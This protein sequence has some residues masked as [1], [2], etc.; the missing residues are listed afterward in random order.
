M[1]TIYLLRHG[2]VEKKYLDCF[3]GKIDCNLSTKG[4]KTSLK[5]AH[6]LLSQSIDFVI[7]SG[8]KRTDYVGKLLKKQGITHQV[9]SDFQE[10]DFGDC[11]G[12]TWAEI[13][14]KFP[15]VVNSYITD[16][17]SLQYPN[18]EKIL[19]AQTRV[20][21]AW[22]KLLNTTFTKA[23]IVGHSGINALLIAYLNQVDINNVET[24]SLGDIIELRV[25]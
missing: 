10:I 24:Q 8:L 6:F 19:D 11:S 7:T 13:Q 22:K 17:K 4:K 23:A 9:I 25:I 18:G 5:N 2:E 16:V 12:K 20:I 21:K 3:K 1:K 15:D 14:Q